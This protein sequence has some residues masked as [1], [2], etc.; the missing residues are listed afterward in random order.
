MS[1]RSLVSPPRVDCA[2]NGFVGAGRN[3]RVRKLPAMQDSDKSSSTLLIVVGLFS[4][5]I[6]CYLF[7]FLDCLFSSVWKWIGNCRDTL[8]VLKTLLD[9]RLTLVLCVDLYLLIHFLTSATFLSSSAFLSSNFFSL[10]RILSSSAD[11]C[12]LL[13]A[14]SWSRLAVSDKANP[15]PVLKSE[16]MTR[17]MAKATTRIDLVLIFAS[18]SNMTC[19]LQTGALYTQQ[20]FHYA[21]MT[22]MTYTRLLILK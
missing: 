2:P 22:S 13:L 3:H 10:L 5:M 15:S 12:F 17:K 6:T 7:S 16:A 20:L 18:A 19:M 11:A 4:K 21:N 9:Y 14:F 1:V 8:D